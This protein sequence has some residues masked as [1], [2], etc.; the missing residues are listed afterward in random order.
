MTG[1]AD[2]EIK[3]SSTATTQL[4]V[5][6]VLSVIMSIALIG[7]AMTAPNPTLGLAAF[8]GSGISLVVLGLRAM[9]LYHSRIPLRITQE[10]VTI[11]SSIKVSVPRSQITGAGLHPKTGEPC[12]YFD[13]PASD[14]RGPLRLPMR[15]I[16]TENHVV[17]GQLI[18]VVGRAPE[19]A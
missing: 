16:D 13:D 17:L 18:D 11:G 3:R 19:A 1:P 9:T 10:T 12:L 5:K 2:L 14:H 7:Y 8:V 4:I 6:V 15:F